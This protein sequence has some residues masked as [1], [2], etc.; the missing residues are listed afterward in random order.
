M[1][2]TLNTTPRSYVVR[3]GWIPGSI[4]QGLVEREGEIPIFRPQ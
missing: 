1:V 2:N 4:H 3:L